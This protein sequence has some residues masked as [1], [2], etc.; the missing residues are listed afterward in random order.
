MS[1]RNRN[2]MPEVL[3]VEPA[4]E[5]LPSKA[6]MLRYTTDNNLELRR[7]LADCNRGNWFVRTVV[8]IASALKWGAQMAL[9]LVAL[10][11]LVR[12]EALVREWFPDPAIEAEKSQP[13]VRTTIYHE[14]DPVPTV[15]EDDKVTK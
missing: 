6:D 9:L 10:F 4:R 11:L 12:V 15:P 2:G 14:P 1:E 8:A 7:Q 5:P 13:E 3:P